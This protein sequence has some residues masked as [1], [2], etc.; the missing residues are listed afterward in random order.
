VD[1]TAARNDANGENRHCIGETNVSKAVERN[2]EKAL[3]K[4]RYEQGRTVCPKRFNLFSGIAKRLT[5]SLLQKPK[6]QNKRK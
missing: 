2:Q 4:S 6:K 3:F 5:M 1:G